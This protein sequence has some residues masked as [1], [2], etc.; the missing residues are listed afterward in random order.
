METDK[1]TR[2]VSTEEKRV[3]VVSLERVRVQLCVNAL[4]AGAF[5]HFVCLLHF[6]AR[7]FDCECLFLPLLSSL[8]FPSFSPLFILPSAICRVPSQLHCREKCVHRT[9][10]VITGDLLELGPIFGLGFDSWIQELDWE[11][12]SAGQ[13][14]SKS[15]RSRSESAIKKKRLRRDRHPAGRRGPGPATP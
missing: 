5:A 13:A 7:S 11:N 2:P 6:F 4:N 15:L 12:L 10:C 3:K 14:G 1:K 9:P 8:F